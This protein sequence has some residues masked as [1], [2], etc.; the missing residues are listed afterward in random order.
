MSELRSLISLVRLK[1]SL[2]SNDPTLLRE[3]HSISSKA[4]QLAEHLKIE[5]W[6]LTAGPKQMEA[7]EAWHQTPRRFSRFALV[8]GNR[9][10]KSFTGGRLLFAKTLRDT[11]PKN[12][13]YWCVA[14]NEQKSIEIQQKEIWE[15]LPKWMFGD[16]F[17]DEKNGFG[18]QRRSI[19]LDEKGR[20]VVVRFKSAAQYDSDPASFEGEKVQD[21]WVDETIQEGLWTRLL[22]RLVDTNGRMLVTT[23]PDDDWIDDKFGE[24]DVA[25]EAIGV[26]A[27][28]LTIYD[29]PNISKQGVQNFYESLSEDERTMRIWGKAIHKTGL[30]YTQFIRDYKPDGHLVKPFVI[31]AHWPRRRVMDVGVDHPTVCLWFCIAPNDNVYLYREYAARRTTVQEDARRIIE[32]SK[33]E[34]FDRHTIIDPSAFNITKSNPKSV[35]TQF[36]ECGI[37]CVKGVRSNNHPQGGE[38]ALVQNVKRWLE[39]QR[40]F[41][42][43]NCQF[44][45]REFRSWKHKRDK[46]NNPVG[47]GGYEDKNNDALDCVKYFLATNP[48]Y[49]APQSEVS[50]VE[51]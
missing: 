23:I 40:F 8:G 19:I 41:V 27:R 30:V 47:R 4:Y 7:V 44:T 16:Q 26:F 21:I 13:I 14:P 22:A 39:T 1:E 3:L 37:P 10:G 42:F 49:E 12:G 50:S 31:P 29:N 32:M 45:I 33:G 5:S 11:A 2:A 46:D 15:A 25:D 6:M 34:T 36:A 20:H 48:S 9:S 51:F 28:R 35:G 38:F 18:G 43:D 17:Y 24:D